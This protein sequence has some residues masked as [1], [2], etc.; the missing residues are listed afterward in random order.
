MDTPY[1][2]TYY[3][4]DAR[5]Q[6]TAV[7]PPAGR[8]E[9]V[10]D[11]DGK[12]ISKSS[13]AEGDRRFLYDHG[14]LLRELDGDSGDPLRSYASTGDDEYGDLV[15]E[16]D[17]SGSG[18]TLYHQYD[19]QWSTNALLDDPGDVVGRLSYRAFGL[20]ATG[21]GSYSTSGNSP[22]HHSRKSAGGSLEKR[23]GGPLPPP[24]WCTCGA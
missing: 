4:W 8:V 23:G 15:S 22:F 5:G 1:E 7:E 9:F 18:G 6:L 21:P 2:T 3:E 13:Y 11:A 14:S 24:T 19:A 20:T 10:Y 12:R 17:D 16:H